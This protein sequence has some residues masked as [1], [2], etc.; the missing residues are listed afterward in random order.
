V[1]LLE[2]QTLDP[3]PCIRQALW[4]MNNTH[5]ILLTNFGNKNGVPD[6]RYG[7]HAVLLL[8]LLLLSLL[9]WVQRALLLS[10]L[11]IQMI[12]C[13]PLV[14]THHNNMQLIWFLHVFHMF[15]YPILDGGFELVFELGLPSLQNLFVVVM[16][17]THTMGSS[18]K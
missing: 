3:P 4:L 11:E 15:L 2:A 13:Q 5:D 17:Q 12:F 10:F 16:K 9:V 14:V 18:S 1:D 8:L 7:G 6:S